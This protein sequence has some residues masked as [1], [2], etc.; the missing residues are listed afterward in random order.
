MQSSGDKL[1][2]LASISI[3]E[4]DLRMIKD[5]EVDEVLGF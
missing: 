3:T 5:V 4:G 1:L 2:V